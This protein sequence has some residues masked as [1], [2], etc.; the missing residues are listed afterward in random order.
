[1]MR[2]ILAFVAVGLLSLAFASSALAG[3]ATED[4]YGGTAGVQQFNENEGSEGTES[5]SSNTVLAA[6][7]SD[8]GG[9]GSSGS[10]PFTGLDIVLIALGGVALVGTGLLIRRTTR[11][12]A[13]A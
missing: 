6:E 9:S 5:E 4:A 7:S 8:E 3:S 13:S 12:D 11:S 2:K 1:M 10:L